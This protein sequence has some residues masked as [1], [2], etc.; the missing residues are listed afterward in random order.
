M[1]GLLPHAHLSLCVQLCWYFSLHTVCLS[2]DCFAA[3]HFCSNNSATCKTVYTRG[4]EVGGRG[5]G[6]VG[7]LVPLVYNLGGRERGEA[8]LFCAAL[9]NV[10]AFRPHQRRERSQLVGVAYAGNQQGIANFFLL[11]MSKSNDVIV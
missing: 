8:W 6:G 11:L 4:N 5:E 7:S 9:R 2:R 1:D 3:K 10:L